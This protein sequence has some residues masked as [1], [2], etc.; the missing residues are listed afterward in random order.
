MGYDV[1]L[2]LDGLIL[3]FLCVTI[4]SNILVLPYGSLNTETKNNE[5]RIWID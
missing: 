4:F 1:S 5:I 3:V 2:L